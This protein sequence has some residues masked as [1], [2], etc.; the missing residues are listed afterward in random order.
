MPAAGDPQRLIRDHQPA[1]RPHL[2]TAGVLR[3]IDLSKYLFVR[4]VLVNRAMHQPIPGGFNAAFDRVPRDHYNIPRVRIGS[5]RNVMACRVVRP[6]P[7]LALAGSVGGGEPSVG[8]T[9]RS[10]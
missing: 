3:F 9:A 2:A 8:A 7:S 1:P 6:A 5:N 4:S 10:R